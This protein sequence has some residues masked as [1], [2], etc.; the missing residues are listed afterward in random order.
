MQSF[1]QYGLSFIKNTHMEMLLNI[2]LYAYVL[3]PLLIFSARVFDQSLGIVRI[4]LATK[5]LTLPAFIFGFFESFVWLLAIGQIMTKIDNLFYYV[6]FAAGF[7][8]GNVFGI[9]L[10]RKLS[11][12][13]VMIRVVFHHDSDHSIRQLKEKGFRV[14]IV[15]AQ[16][17]DQPVKMLFSTIKRKQINEFVENLMQTNPTAFY[18]VE[19]VK[20]VRSN[21]FASQ[22][23]RRL[24]VFNR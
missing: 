1:E 3:L 9:Y 10:E 18:A 8:S 5:G 15:D 6:V 11:I 17:M 21:Y 4:I 13:F 16:G 14:T 23:S 20:Q 12:G 2:D 19:D 22:K 24:N 7:A